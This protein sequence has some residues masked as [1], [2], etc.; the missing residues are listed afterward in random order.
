MEK[1]VIELLKEIQEDLKDPFN[2]YP[3]EDRMLRLLE[4]LKTLPG[5]D[6]SQMLP[7]FE[8]IR[9]NIEENYRIA[10]GWLEE[11]TRFMEKRGL[12]LRA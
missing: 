11:L 8:E 3:L 6:L 5:E 9:K 4:V 7:I 12:D 1:E 10:L 2:P